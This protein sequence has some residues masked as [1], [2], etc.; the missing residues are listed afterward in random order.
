MTTPKPFSPAI[1]DKLD[2][3]LDYLK[4]GKA[5]DPLTPLEIGGKKERNL[6]RYIFY[7]LSNITLTNLGKGIN[8]IRGMQSLERVVADGYFYIKTQGGITK[9]LKAESEELIKAVT[10]LL[11]PEEYH[12]REALCKELLKFLNQKFTNAIKAEAKIRTLPHK[13]VLPRAV[14]GIS[15]RNA[16][17]RASDGFSYEDWRKGD[18]RYGVDEYYK[19]GN[20]GRGK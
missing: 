1:S 3:V 13:R 9:T 14:E 20:N 4:S 19:N 5:L 2:L 17:K 16:K 15:E 12:S 8:G 7:N 18:S 11:V 6:L 10:P